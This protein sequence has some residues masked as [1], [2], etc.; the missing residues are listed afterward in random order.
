MFVLRIVT[1]RLE[2]FSQRVVLS[3]IIGNLEFRKSGKSWILEFNLGKSWN[4]NSCAVGSMF[5]F[6]NEESKEQ[7]PTTTPAHPPLPAE[8]TNFILTN[9]QGPG[10]RIFVS[11][12]RNKQL[13]NYKRNWDSEKY[14]PRIRLQ[15]ES[16][17]STSHIDFINLWKFIFK[18]RVE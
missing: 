7:S 15:L 17:S 16:E 8:V 5:R 18:N 6:D 1:S 12:V 10:F 9:S 2:A 3:I 11:S 13:K 4:W 14:H